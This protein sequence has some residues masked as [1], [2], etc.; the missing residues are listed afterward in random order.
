M[1]ITEPLKTS[2]E[3]HSAISENSYFLKLYNQALPA[4]GILMSCPLQMYTGSTPPTPNPGGKKIH[5]PWIAASLIKPN[6]TST[7]RRSAKFKEKLER[8]GAIH[9]LPTTKENR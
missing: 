7:F 8:L 6:F 3:A 2:D 1:N 4:L 9:I 5:V